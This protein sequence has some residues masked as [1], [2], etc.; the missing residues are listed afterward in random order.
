[1]R[2]LE[3]CANG[4][5]RRQFQL[6]LNGR[7]LTWPADPARPIGLR[8]RQ[9]VLYPCLHPRLPLDV[10]LSLHLVDARGQSVAAWRLEDGKGC[11][12]RFLSLRP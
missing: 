7:P 6:Y 9:S 3:L 8:Y 2:R 12:N 10:P 5:L 11:F 1:M 4:P